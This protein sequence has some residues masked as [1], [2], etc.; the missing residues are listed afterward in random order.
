MVAAIVREANP[1]RIVLFGPAA[2]ATMHEASDVDPLVVPKTAA[3]RQTAR[4]LR[5]HATRHAPPLHIVVAP[6]AD[7]RADTTHGT[8]RGARSADARSRARRD[9]RGR[10]GGTDKTRRGGSEPAPPASAVTAGIGRA[11]QPHQPKR[12]RQGAN[13]RQRTA[14]PGPKRKTAAQAR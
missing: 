13:D 7:A 4:R 14:K 8:V 3:P 6:A 5:R 11:A 2:S 9:A 1:E 10:R 12:T